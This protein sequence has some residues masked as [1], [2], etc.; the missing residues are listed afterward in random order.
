MDASRRQIPL[1]PFNVIYHLL[2]DIKS[3]LSKRIPATDEDVPT[4]I[5]EIL[6]VF[7]ITDR[8]KK[9][10]VAGCRV[11]EGILEKKQL[12]KLVRQGQVI[13]RGIN[14]DFLFPFIIRLMS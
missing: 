6:Q 10:P 14:Q 7:D 8:N 12:F 4:G 2:H 13:H 11:V 9:V 1:R 5:A 3:E